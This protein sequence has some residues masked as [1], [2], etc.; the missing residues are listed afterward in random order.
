[1]NCPWE[2]GMCETTLYLKE[3][4]K[5]KERRGQAKRN[6]V[7]GLVRKLKSETAKCIERLCVCG[8]GGQQIR[9]GEGWRVQLSWQSGCPGLNL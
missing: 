4:R 2:T 1:M 9:A 8:E 7:S 6:D 5:E 3:V